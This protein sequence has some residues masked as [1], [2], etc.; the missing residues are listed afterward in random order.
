M[1]LLPLA[2]SPADI[3]RL[4]Y[5]PVSKDLLSEAP[6]PAG[7]WKKSA[8]AEKRRPRGFYVWAYLPSSR[9]RAREERPFASSSSTRSQGPRTPPFICI[10]LREASAAEESIMRYSGELLSQ[11]EAPAMT[12]SIAR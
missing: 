2:A 1:W 11:P 12:S 8:A 4:F 5:T 10:P 3:P 6:R 9:A 7:L